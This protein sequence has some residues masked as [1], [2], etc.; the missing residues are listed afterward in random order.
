MKLKVPFFKITR[1]QTGSKASCCIKSPL[2]TYMTKCILELFCH[3]S[4]CPWCMG[5]T[6]II[7]KGRWC[8]MTLCS[9]VQFCVTYQNC[10]LYISST[11]LIYLPNKHTGTL[12]EFWEKTLINVLRLFLAS[13]NY[14]NWLTWFLLLLHTERQESRQSIEIIFTAQN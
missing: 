1:V 13:K 10:S 2:L 9:V 3:D 5:Y 12:T 14:F 7:T 4:N 11:T 6:A 8:F